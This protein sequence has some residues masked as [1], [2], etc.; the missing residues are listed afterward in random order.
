MRGQQN[1]DQKRIVIKKGS[2]D[3]V[4]NVTLPDVVR[5]YCEVIKA[6]I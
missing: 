1:S 2:D 3:F 6:S 5:F 4:D